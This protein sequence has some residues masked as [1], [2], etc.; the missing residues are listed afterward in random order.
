[1]GNVRPALSL[2]VG[3]LLSFLAGM[4]VE[5][6]IGNFRSHASN[7]RWILEVFLGLVS[8]VMAIVYIMKRNE[9]PRPSWGSVEWF[10]K[11]NKPPSMFD[12]K[13]D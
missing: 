9:K 5:R 13:D 12:K 1:M 7:H 8:L 6:G 10:Y 11:R 3:I 4:S 2:A